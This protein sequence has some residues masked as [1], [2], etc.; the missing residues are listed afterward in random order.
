MKLVFIFGLLC[1]L[2]I[3]FLFLR[4]KIRPQYSLQTGVLALLLA[5]VLLLA[6]SFCTI[7]REK[8]DASVPPSSAASVEQGLEGSM[9][10]EEASMSEEAAE[11]EHE[12]SE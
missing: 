11:A 9:P 5:G 6:L 4:S 2:S 7:L 3:L 8:D 1:F 12:T 10:E